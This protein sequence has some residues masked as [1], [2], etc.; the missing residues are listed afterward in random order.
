MY[1]KYVLGL[2]P[3][4]AEITQSLSSTS[5]EPQSQS[6][7]LSPLFQ[8]QNKHSSLVGGAW[9]FHDC[10][11]Y[12]SE[13]NTPGLSRKP[14]PTTAAVFVLGTPTDTAIRAKHSCL[15][16]ANAAVKPVFQFIPAQGGTATLDR[17]PQI[18]ILWGF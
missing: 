1:N 6:V 18:C 12:G 15:S 17:A 5:E 13:A 8:L 16:W 11:Q 3:P 9:N 2:V 14:Q 10:G 4:F 7:L